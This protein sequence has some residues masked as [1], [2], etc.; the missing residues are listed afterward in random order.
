MNSPEVL[1]A[2]PPFDFTGIN[3]EERPRTKQAGY[4]LYYPHMGLCSIGATLARAGFS[5][6]I[7]DGMVDARSEEE[8]V[9]LIIAARPR[10]LGLSI[11]TP[12]LPITGKLISKIRKSLQDIVIVAGGPH[13]SCDPEIVHALGAD[14]GVVGDG[15]TP[16]LKIAGSVLRGVALEP[17]TPGIAVPGAVAETQ[18]DLSDLDSIPPPDRRLLSDPD[19]YFNPFV[20]ARTTSLLSA[21]GCPFQ[22]SFCCRTISMGG[23]RPMEERVVLAEMERAASEGYRFISL[24]DETF[25]YDRDRAVRIAGEMLK[26]KLP[27]KWSCQTRADLIDAEALK[28]FRAA[29]C[30]NLSFGLEAGDEEVRAGM[31]KKIRDTDYEKAVS[32]CRKA[33][34]TTNL[35]VIIGAPYETKPQIDKSIETAVAL[36]PDYVVYNVGTLFP[37]TREYEKRIEAGEIDRTIWD[38][39][40]RGET[41]L[42][43]LSKTLGRSELS[44]LLRKGYSRFY[45]RPGYIVKKIRSVR[46]PR[47][48]AVLARQARTVIA[49][50]VV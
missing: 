16:M 46:S 38:S 35:F 15:E 11:T 32:A 1:L 31:D 39:Y 17:R 26:R 4:Y 25:T 19:A 18:P 22:C 48:I 47:D 29:G 40:M 12:A 21:R 10:L 41:P 44:E 13:V 14:F 20:K 28:V 2:A 50:Y 9:A 34:I 42:P 30:V 33:G 6:K 3:I 36:E 37:G 8:F 43:V 23:Y 24:I 5:V 27:F 7:L 49:D 45:L